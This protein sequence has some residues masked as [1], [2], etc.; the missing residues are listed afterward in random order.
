MPEVVD[1]I[2]IEGKGHRPPAMAHV[3][4]CSRLPCHCNIAHGASMQPRRQRVCT[5]RT[6]R[7]IN[8]PF[9]MTCRRRYA[10]YRC[11]LRRTSSLCPARLSLAHTPRASISTLS[12]QSSI[13]N[14]LLLF[15]SAHVEVDDDSA[16]VAEDKFMLIEELR[17]VL[18]YPHSSS[19]IT[20]PACGRTARAPI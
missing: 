17:S 12:L 13:L 4:V 19:C 16:I 15:T 1:E 9:A 8:K 3:T 14:R 20:S 2:S 7:A 5:S 11:Y 10:A 18:P 6:V